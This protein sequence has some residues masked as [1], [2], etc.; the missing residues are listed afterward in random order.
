MGVIV[1]GVVMIRLDTGREAAF[2]HEWKCE[3]VNVSDVDEGTLRS[4]ERSFQ[5]A[6]SDITSVQ[7]FH[8]RAA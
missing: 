3:S 4:I 8:Y 5:S 2:H 6:Y 1:A 7:I